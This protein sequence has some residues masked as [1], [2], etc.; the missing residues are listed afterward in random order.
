V[1]NRR[2]MTRRVGFFFRG[3]EGLWERL[4]TQVLGA[5]AIRGIKRKKEAF[6]RKL[7]MSG[8]QM[9][10]KLLLRSQKHFL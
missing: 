6:V 9:V 10:H 5:Y 7:H 3:E 1:L 8:I 4:V 2:V